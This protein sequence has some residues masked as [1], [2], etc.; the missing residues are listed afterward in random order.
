MPLCAVGVT[1][2]TSYLAS[3]S[4]EVG[5]VPSPCS[6]LDHPHSFQSPNAGLISAVPKWGRGTTPVFSGTCGLL[7]NLVDLSNFIVNF[8]FNNFFYRL[9]EMLSI[10]WSWFLKMFIAIYSYGKSKLYSSFE[11]IESTQ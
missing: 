2:V 1:W 6:A 3:V 5:A 9:I 7:S 10:I 8:S 11:L 4:G